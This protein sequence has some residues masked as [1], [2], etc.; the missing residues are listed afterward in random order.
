M[1]D[2]S[3]LQVIG[4]NRSGYSILLQTIDKTQ[5]NKK[6]L[7]K[8]D[9]P[10]QF[11]HDGIVQMFLGKSSMLHYYDEGKWFAIQISD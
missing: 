1:D 3:G 9:S 4:K 2:K 5:L 8:K 11:S 7:K 10:E 6:Y